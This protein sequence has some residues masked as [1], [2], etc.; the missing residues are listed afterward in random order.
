MNDYVYFPGCSLKENSKHYEESILPVFK[1]IGLPLEEL[2]DWNCCGATAYFSV[3]DTMAAA[4]CGR[5]LSL[6]E[7]QGKDILAPCAGC[8]LTLKKSN[9]YLISG[10]DRAPK[11][12]N[13]LKQAGCEYQGRVKVKHP[14]E[15]LIKDIGLEAIRKK[16]RH[17]L[18]GLRVACYYGCQLVRPFTDFDDPDYPMTLDLLMEAIGA[19]P[20]AYS[21]KTRC[22]GGLLAGTIENVGLR[23]NY[24]LLKEAKRK[25]ADVIV[26]ICPLCLFNLE[27]L[28]DK[29]VK[30]FKDDVKMPIFFFSQLL[31]LALGL[32]QDD[33]GF[34]RSVIPLKAFWEK[35]RN[36]G[37]H[38]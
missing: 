19:E 23:L 24:L 29:I 16:V 33:L 34:S 18:T 13:D 14:L 20:V 9:N 32:S 17:K 35:I 21:G 25:G 28:Q 7:K 36:G 11:I 37:Q 30:T 15:I 1:E 38:V 3:D 26:T 6:A 2:A 31:G 22:C 12:L 8:Y 27:L 4:I 5:N 10:K